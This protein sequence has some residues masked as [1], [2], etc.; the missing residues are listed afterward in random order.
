MVYVNEK[1]L[2]V[3][4]CC[5]SQE[6]SQKDLFNGNIFENNDLNYYHQKSET[7]FKHGIFQ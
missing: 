6:M 4:E 5:G 2:I 3:V 1:F 7:N